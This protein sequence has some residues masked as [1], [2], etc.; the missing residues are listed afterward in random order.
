MSPDLERLV[1]LPGAGKAHSELCRAGHPTD[2]PRF[3]GEIEYSVHVQGPYGHRMWIEVMADSL[4]KA[5]ARAVE[6]IKMRELLPCKPFEGDMMEVI[7]VVA[8]E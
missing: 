1:N 4:E 7:E 2:Y 3:D 6:I 5:E 8:F